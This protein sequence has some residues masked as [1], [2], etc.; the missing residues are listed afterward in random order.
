M[1][2]FC[3]LFI[4]ITTFWK[5]HWGILVLFQNFLLSLTFSY[6]MLLSGY[7][8]TLLI[9]L[10]FFYRGWYKH[11]YRCQSAYSDSFS[12][13]YIWPWLAFCMWGSWTLFTVFV[14]LLQ[15]YFLFVVSLVPQTGEYCF[16]YF[17]V[18]NMAL[19]FFQIFCF[20]LVKKEEARLCLW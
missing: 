17:F 11:S 4:W 7:M 10:W 3:T 5:V 16:G 1:S 19:K 13:S 9:H 18:K 15:P 2:C 20:N 6:T 12:S 14:S 8:L